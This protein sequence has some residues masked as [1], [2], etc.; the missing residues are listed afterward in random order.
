MDTEWFLYIRYPRRAGEKRVDT[1][2]FTNEKEAKATFE[3]LQYN[4]NIERLQLMKREDVPWEPVAEWPDPAP[5]CTYMLWNKEACSRLAFYKII[6]PKE[7]ENQYACNT[8]T[9]KAFLDQLLDRIEP[10]GITIRR[11]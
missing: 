3:G 10:H 6:L 2:M 11:I 7:Q 5:T 9:G 8:H 4:D 1:R